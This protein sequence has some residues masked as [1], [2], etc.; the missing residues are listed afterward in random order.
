MPQRTV[1]KLAA[2]GGS[3]A[4]LYIDVI[5]RQYLQLARLSCLVNSF[6]SCFS[7]GTVH[8][9]RISVDPEQLTLLIISL[10]E[11]ADW[12]SIQT[13]KGTIT[14]WQ[15]TELWAHSPS[16]GR[17]PGE[18]L[19]RT[20]TQR[21]FLDPPAALTAVTKGDTDGGGRFDRWSLSRE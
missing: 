20:G 21:L 15:P 19:R 9:V 3:G 2:R 17:S 6:K 12:D 18:L 11:V 16:G 5:V 4:V 10:S 13:N 7:A 8:C 14:Q 1:S